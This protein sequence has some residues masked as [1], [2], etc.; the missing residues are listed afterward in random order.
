M[1][2]SSVEFPMMPSTNTRQDTTVLMYLKVS[3]I[4]MGLLHGGGRVRGGAPAVLLALGI[5]GGTDDR[6]TLALDPLNQKILVGGVIISPVSRSG[7][8]VPAGGNPLSSPRTAATPQARIRA[9]R[10][11]PHRLGSG[12]ILLPAP[13][14]VGWSLC[15]FQSGEQGKKDRTLGCAT[16]ATPLQ[17]ASAERSRAAA[18][19]AQK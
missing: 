13:E 16:L 3:L 9:T 4:S 6:G 17:T 18:I 12:G 2:L 11:R 8:V 19:R 7:R 10:A 5:C 15:R 14:G 1:I